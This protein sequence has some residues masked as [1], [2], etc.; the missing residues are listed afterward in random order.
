[1]RDEKHTRRYRTGMWQDRFVIPWMCVVVSEKTDKN[2]P[3]SQSESQESIYK[4]LE[5][6]AFLRQF[7]VFF[8]SNVLTNLIFKGHCPEFV[9]TLSKTKTALP[10]FQRI[11]KR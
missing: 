6:N 5:D 9:T 7:L 4:I 10:N 3:E 11:S 8:S 2:P 1:M